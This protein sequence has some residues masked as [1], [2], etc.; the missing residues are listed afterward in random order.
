[1]RLPRQFATV[2]LH[3]ADCIKP[4]ATLRLQHPTERQVLI[5]LYYGR[6]A[7]TRFPRRGFQSKRL[8]RIGS[9][10]NA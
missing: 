6:L 3:Q 1:M 8:D 10:P 7:S 9:V 4:I 5:V 2:R